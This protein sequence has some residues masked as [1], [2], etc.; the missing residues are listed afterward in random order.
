[1]YREVNEM[2][3]CANCGVLVPA[4]EVVRERRGF[5]LVFCSPKCIEIYDRYKYPRYREQIDEMEQK[6]MADLAY[7]YLTAV[8]QDG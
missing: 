5:Q 7:G 8:Y 1:M 6:G 2:P 4:E 3:H